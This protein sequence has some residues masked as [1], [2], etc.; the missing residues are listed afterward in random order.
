MA[1]LKNLPDVAILGALAVIVV[2]TFV[3][4]HNYQPRNRYG[5]TTGLKDFYE[6]FRYPSKLVPRPTGKKEMF[7]GESAEMMFKVKPGCT[8]EGNV[9]GSNDGDSDT[10]SVY[11][12]DANVLTYTTKAIRKQGRGWY[13]PQ[14]SPKF[15]FTTSNNTAI[16]KIHID[17]ADKYGTSPDRIRIKPISEVKK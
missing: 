12:D 2:G 8:Y 15:R 14:F 3:A 17:S 11:A 16:I 9:L 10:I 6:D 13:E 1:N 5:I 4:A 7:Q